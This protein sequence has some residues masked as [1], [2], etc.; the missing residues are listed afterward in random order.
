[1]EK[2]F[3]AYVDCGVPV[4]V[5]SAAINGV[6][7]VS[8]P[9]TAVRYNYH[10]DVKKDVYNS[11]N[12]ELSSL[13]ANLFRNMK[14]LDLTLY[15]L[16]NGNSRLGYT[17]GRPKVSGG[18]IAAIIFLLLFS[19]GVGAAFSTI[20]FDIPA[21]LV[22]LIA[23]SVTALIFMCIPLVAIKSDTDERLNK[24]MHQRFIARVNDYVNIIMRNQKKNM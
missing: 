17:I 5:L 14:W 12:V 22:F 1:M 20:P 16:G 6:L 3:S 13:Y 15:D 24:M 23:F 2:V 10:I 21:L 9:L 18:L 11:K 7:M 19:V 4:D 8:G